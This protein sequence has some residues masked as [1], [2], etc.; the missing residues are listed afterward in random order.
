MRKGS[1]IDLSLSSVRIWKIFYF[2]VILLFYHTLLKVPIEVDWKWKPLK[3]NCLFFKDS[4]RW[5]KGLLRKKGEKFFVWSFSRCKKLLSRKWVL[6]L[7]LLYERFK[8][9]CSD[10]CFSVANFVKL[11]SIFGELFIW[12]TGRDKKAGVDDKTEKKTTFTSL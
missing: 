1:V 2:S 10:V 8:A 11:T 12:E 6:S 9:S 5:S 4:F 3:W 7:F